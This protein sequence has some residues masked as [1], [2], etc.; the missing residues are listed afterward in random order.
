MTLCSLSSC[1]SFLTQF[2][3]VKRGIWSNLPITWEA[4]QRLYETLCS[5]LVL[6]PPCHPLARGRKETQSILEESVTVATLCSEAPCRSPVEQDKWFAASC[7][8]LTS[9][10]AWLWAP[11]INHRQ[12]EEE[13]SNEASCCSL[14]Q[15]VDGTAHTQSQWRNQ[16]DDAVKK[17]EE[18]DGWRVG[19]EGQGEDGLIVWEM[20]YRRRVTR[21]RIKL[22]LT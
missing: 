16:Y 10:W 15:T 6:V 17:D 5:P 3:E 13:E 12:F 1:S 4:F 20:I 21:S 19:N 14:I 8:L 2:P 18:N 11:V 22:V 9:L 7:L